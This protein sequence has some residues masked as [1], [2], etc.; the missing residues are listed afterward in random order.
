MMKDY[1][2]R[3]VQ[4][5]G[6]PPVIARVKV[7]RRGPKQIVVERCEA[8]GYGTR[9]ER[10]IFERMFAPTVTDAVGRW[11]VDVTQQIETCR[12]ELQRVS[13]LL[14]LTPKPDFHG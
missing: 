3:V 11:R 4:R 1:V 8:T 2:Y 14:A 13:G 9:F 5:G 10:D 6:D 12:K 7:V